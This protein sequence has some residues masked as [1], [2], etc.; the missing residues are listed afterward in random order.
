MI[1]RSSAVRP[2]GGAYVGSLVIALGLLVVSVAGLAA[3]PADLY[4][5]SEL[6]LISRGADAANLL[7]VLPILL[8]SMWL[9]RRGSLIGLLLW[10]GALFY[11]VYAYVPYVVGAPFTALFFVHVGLVT[12]S[13]FTII[14]ILASI[15]ADDVRQRLARGPARNVGAALVVI[16]L[17]AY[18]GLIGLAVSALGDPATEVG[19]RPLA[20]ADW[21]VGTP[22]LLVGGLLLWGRAALGYV[23]GPGTLLVS[24]LGGVA[25]AIA[26]VVDNMLGGPQTEPAVVGVHLAI[27]TV[28]I[29]LLVH[30]ARG[31]TRSHVVPPAST[32][33]PVHRPPMPVARR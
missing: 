25:F 27:A 24:G 26:A 3:D 1:P 15:D 12:V 30:F 29:G 18:A 11:V 8:G 21:V 28:S 33:A 2:L 4:G 13:G 9:A 20:V 22:V 31:A 6:V 32:N 10:P 14:G 19:T 5:S 7:L 17:L 16:A 23:V